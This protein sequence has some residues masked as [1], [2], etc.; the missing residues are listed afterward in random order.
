M[1]I[2]HLKYHQIDFNKYNECI[3]KSYN[4]RI[5]AFS[6]YLDI[7]T[8]KK[9]ECLVLD[10][11]KAV[12]PLPFREKYFIKYIYNPLWV[13]QL[14][15]FSIEKMPEIDM[16]IKKAFET[17]KLIDIRLNTTN[18]L[19][20]FTAEK[21]I[22]QTHFLLFKEYNNL[23]INF[24]KDR[25]RDLNKAKKENLTWKINTS[26]DEFLD[27][28]KQNLLERKSPINANDLNRFKQLLEKSIEKDKG[29]IFSIYNSKHI[30]VAAVFFLKHK[31]R[32]TTLITLRN[33]KY[34]KN[35]SNTFLIEQAIQ[36]YKN[37]FNIFDFGGS[38][39]SSIASYYQSLRASENTYYEIQYN[40]LPLVYKIFKSS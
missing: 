5:Y 17:Y 24:R 40:N 29:E 33:K 39:I 18:E 8:E 25:I 1:Q 19:K 12:M 11:Y 14:G 10:D 23:K 38:S 32:V 20:D 35:G 37:K 9:W 16:F 22:K 31:E 15:V 27:L 34:H 6:W 28:Y 3:E 21:K 30:L 2:T 4:S 7:V 26:I 36:Y 13:L